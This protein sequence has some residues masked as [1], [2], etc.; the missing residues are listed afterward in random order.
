MAGW[1]YCLLRG[2]HIRY[3][4][5]NEDEARKNYEGKIWYCIA[6]AAL[7][8]LHWERY[9][10]SVTLGRTYCIAW[11]VSLLAYS[12]LINVHTWS[13]HSFHHHLT[14]AARISF[15]AVTFSLNFCFL[16]VLRLVSVRK[17]R[18]LY[19]GYHTLNRP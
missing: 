8:A 13:R 10:G 19:F 17:I 4:M 14:S 7:G 5:G 2:S 11:G 3:D 6:R 12:S 16:S 15:T 1:L 18:M 9:I